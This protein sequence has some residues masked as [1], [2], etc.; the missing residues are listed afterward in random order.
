MNTIELPLTFAT[1]GI[2]GLGGL[3][4]L[5]GA[6]VSSLAELLA[7]LRRRGGWV[8]NEARPPGGHVVRWGMRRPR[9]RPLVETALAWQ[10][11]SDESPEQAGDG[12]GAVALSERE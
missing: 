6:V 4:L 2:L 12:E 8:G 7:L 1:A 10:D 9:P 11:G 5:M 3:A